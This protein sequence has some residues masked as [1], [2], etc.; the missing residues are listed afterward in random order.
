MAS[1]QQLSED[2]I[3][4]LLY[5]ARAGDLDELRETVDALVPPDQS[6][7]KEQERRRTLAQLLESASNEDGNTPLH[8]CCANGHLGEQCSEASAFPCHSRGLGH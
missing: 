1:N 7:D 8:Y 2:Q 6:S 4:D 5:C 3:D